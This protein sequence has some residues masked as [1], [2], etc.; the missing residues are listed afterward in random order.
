MSA[1]TDLAVLVPMLGRGDMLDRLTTSLHDT[2]PSA[3]FVFI[4]S[5]DA[6]A[7][8]CGKY[9]EVLRT[10]RAKRGDYAVKINTAVAATSEP[11]LFFGAID[12]E[13]T[14]GWF[15]AALAVTSERIRVVG[16]NDLANPRVM[17][18]DHATHF[19][20]ARDYATKPLIDGGP[21]PL[22]TG[23]IHEFVDDEFLGTAT[24]RGAYAFAADSHVRH[25]HPEFDKTAAWDDSYRAMSH[26]IRRSVRLYRSRRALW[27]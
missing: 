4:C 12:I 27:T 18:G 13:F 19:L 2:T 16:T 10:D 5:E 17:R 15:D 20:V 1:D 23:Y 6:D 11:W 22:Y 7:T 25:R 3:R 26:R 8:V 14:P 21:G 24:A 9:G